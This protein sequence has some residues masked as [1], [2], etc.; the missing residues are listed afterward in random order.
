MRVRNDVWCVVYRL[1]TEEDVRPPLHALKALAELTVCNLL[2]LH[3]I[4]EQSCSIPLSQEQPLALARCI[5]LSLLRS[6]CYMPTLEM[7]SVG[8]VTPDLAGDETKFCFC[9]FFSYIQSPILKFYRSPIIFMNIKTLLTTHFLLRNDYCFDSLGTESL[10]I[11]TLERF[12]AAKI[13]CRSW[14][15][16]ETRRHRIIG[17]T[18]FHFVHLCSA[19]SWQIHPLLELLLTLFIFVLYVPNKSHTG[20][21]EQARARRNVKLPIGFS[22][23]RLCAKVHR[24]DFCNIISK[25]NLKTRH[26]SL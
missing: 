1:A 19:Q 10:L 7:R 14:K 22:V 20:T 15:I 25:T 3:C 11:E 2:I 13:C 17:N 8:N 9:S 23:S 4:T 26:P 16:H 24:L 12:N 6:P 5:F 18:K 21:G